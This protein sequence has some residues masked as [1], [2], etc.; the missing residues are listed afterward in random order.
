MDLVEAVELVCRW[1]ISPQRGGS[2]IDWLVYAIERV[3]YDLQRLYGAEYESRTFGSRQCSLCD[4]YKQYRR[5]KTYKVHRSAESCSWMQCGRCRG[6]GVEAVAIRGWSCDGIFIPQP[7][8]RGSTDAEFHQEWRCEEIDYFDLC[9]AL[10]IV[11]QS[12]L[13]FRH[14]RWSCDLSAVIDLRCGVCSTDRLVSD[15]Y[16]VFLFMGC[17]HVVRSEVFDDL[18]ARV[19]ELWWAVIAAQPTDGWRDGWR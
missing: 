3:S 11:F 15:A 5:R 1:T 17:D 16:G 8:D 9:D 13:I 2:E 7:G 6:T 10:R 14:I 12:S 4:G 18:P 19:Q